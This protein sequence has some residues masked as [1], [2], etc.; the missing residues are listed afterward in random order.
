[1]ST[2]L[3]PKVVS[4]SRSIPCHPQLAEQA[5]PETDGTTEDPP[6]PPTSTGNRGR[7]PQPIVQPSH[8]ARR[9]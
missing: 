7:R 2:Q 5:D 6:P 1:M 8:Q 9:R 3:E 4:P